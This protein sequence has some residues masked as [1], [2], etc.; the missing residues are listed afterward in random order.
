[1]SIWR[2]LKISLWVA[3]AFALPLACILDRFPKLIAVPIIVGSILLLI[4]EFK[5]SKPLWVHYKW[6]PAKP[7]CVACGRPFH[8]H[9]HTEVPAEDNLCQECAATILSQLS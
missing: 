1:M 8:S 3:V 4:R 6:N 9:S 7:C 5:Y 2:T